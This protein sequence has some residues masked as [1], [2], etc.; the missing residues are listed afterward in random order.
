[1]EGPRARGVSGPRT[2]V[3]HGFGTRPRPLFAGRGASAALQA[4]GKKRQE[5]APRRAPRD[6][7]HEV[8]PWHGYKHRQQR[9]GVLLGRHPP[10]GVCGRGGAGFAPFPPFG[11]WAALG[12]AAQGSVHW[13][14]VGP[15]TDPNQAKADSFTRPSFKAVCRGPLTGPPHH[16]VRPSSASHS[17]RLGSR[18]RHTT[19]S[20]KVG[21]SA[22]GRSAPRSAENHPSAPTSARAVARGAPSG[23]STESRPSGRG[24]KPETGAPAR[25]E[26]GG[27]CACRAAV[28][29]A[30]PSRALVKPYLLFQGWWVGGLDGWMG[31][32]R[33]ELSAISR[34]LQDDQSRAS[35]IGQR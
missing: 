15:D 32:G 18:A 29:S 31:G 35:F 5:T 23:P 10:G 17:A 16:L 9:A 34:R 1:L 2:R 3:G 11:L 6:S 33:G 8:P 28:M 7:P 21:A 14:G 27:S 22:P 24:S 4:A 26:P 25:T 19:M 12:R 13:Q 20:L 30:Q